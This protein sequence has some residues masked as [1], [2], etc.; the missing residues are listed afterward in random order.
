MFPAWLRVSLGLLGFWLA[1]VAHAQELP[2]LTSPVTDFTD[3]LDA[4]QQQALRAKIRAFEQRKG[5]QVV[6]LVVDRAGDAGIEDYAV[7]VFGNNAIGRKGSDDGVLLVV[8]KDERQVRIEVGYG[9]EGAIPDALAGRIISEFLTP[10]FREGDFFGGIDAAVDR[11]I[12]LIDGEQLP[13][14][15]ADTSGGLGDFWPVS[16]FIGMVLGSVFVSVRGKPGFGLAL[17]AALVAGGM[18]WFLFKMFQ[19]V[20]VS[21]GAAFFM[22]VSTSGGGGFS[23]GR[24]GSGGWSGGS[25]GGNWGGGGSSG[26]SWS[27]GGGRSGGGGASG[28]W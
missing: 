11:L 9:L 16:L 4:A 25:S 21:A 14:P 6:V 15:L 17:L 7:R 28:R 19:A 10:K 8:A 23:S 26:G 2:T 1:L 13:A 12:G 27:G 3:T 20:L 18:C 5:S 22:A 24:G